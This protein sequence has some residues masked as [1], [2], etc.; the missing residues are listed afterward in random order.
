M[1]P[2]S[3]KTDQLASNQQS[4]HH[5]AMSVR[6]DLSALHHLPRQPR[7]NASW[8]GQDHQ[9]LLELPRIPGAIVRDESAQGCIRCRRIPRV[10]DVSRQP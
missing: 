9:R 7:R 1:K 2:Y 4:V 3:I 8:G 6:G 10:R 5:E